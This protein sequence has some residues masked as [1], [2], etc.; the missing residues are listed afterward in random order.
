[1]KLDAIIM[2]ALFTA[3]LLTVALAV[4]QKVIDY[5]DFCLMFK[6]PE[7]AGCAKTF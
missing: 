4:D 2:A 7:W 1:M 6:N 5:A 3:F